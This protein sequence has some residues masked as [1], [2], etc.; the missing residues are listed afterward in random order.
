MNKKKYKRYSTQ[1][2][3]KV[4]IV[5]Q[6]YQKIK[7]RTGTLPSFTQHYILLIAI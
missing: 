3:G 6:P 1:I 2:K 7:T 5:L 4:H